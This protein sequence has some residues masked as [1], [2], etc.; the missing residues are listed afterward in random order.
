MKTRALL[1]LLLLPLYLTAQNNLR[2]R[3]FFL[4]LGAEFR[5]TPIHKSGDQAIASNF[6]NTDLQ[7]SGPAIN[8]GLDYY[9]LQNFSVGF[10]TSIRYDSI[11]IKVDETDPG[12]GMNY[13]T[14]R[15]L[16]FGYHFNLNYHFQ[17]FNKGDLLVNA[18]LSLLNRNSEY[19]RTKS[20]FNA[21]GEVVD[22]TTSSDNYNL[23]ANKI[24]IGYGKG[25]SKIMMGIYISRNTK[26]FEEKT[27]FIIPFICYGFDIVKF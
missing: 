8:V 16:M 22:S 7:N 2:E 10:K 19:V 18:G 21:E 26:Y 4:N 24:S 12:S 20:I 27:A 13:E 5:I 11:T 6:I 23:N 1:F 15:G 14:G 9:L 17:I 3:N 25:R